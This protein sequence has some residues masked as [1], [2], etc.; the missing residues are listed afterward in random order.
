MYCVQTYGYTLAL[1]WP[2]ALV[3]NTQLLAEKRK[4]LCEEGR[5]KQGYST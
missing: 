3:T 2:E 5:C 1:N 4:Q